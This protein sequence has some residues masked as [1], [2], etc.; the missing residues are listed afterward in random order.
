MRFFTVVEIA[1]LLNLSP[2]RVYEAIRQDLLPSVHIGRQVRIEEQ[3]FNEWVRQG[4]LRYAPGHNRA[5]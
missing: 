3:A 4:G 5:S 1:E 2:D